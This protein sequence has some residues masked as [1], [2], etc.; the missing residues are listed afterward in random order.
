MTST[1]PFSWS[2]ALAGLRRPGPP[3]P[4]LLPVG[5]VLLGVCLLALGVMIGLGLAWEGDAHHYLRER[6]P[7]TYLSFV[8]LV[9]TGG[10]CWLTALGL[11]PA[12]FARFWRA[13]ALGFVWLGCDDLFVLHEQIDRGVHGVLA[14]DPDHPLT[15][16]LD[17]AIVGS[18]GAAALALAHG[19]RA[20]LAR[21]RWAVLVL[22]VAFALFAAMVVLDTLHWSKTA[23]DALKV[24]AGTVIFIGVYA[25]RL[26]LTG[27]A[28]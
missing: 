18:Y 12:P 15:D 7:G 5:A 14:I 28:P 22:G 10:L 9:A 23:E 16:R 13:A 2:A 19:F 8:N 1:P 24:V 21:L 25:A 27:R 17:D 26:Q 20:E 4:G 11:G 3:P 6:K